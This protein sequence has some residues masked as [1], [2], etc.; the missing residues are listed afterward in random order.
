MNAQKEI[1][2]IRK[3]CEFLENFFYMNAQNKNK[4]NM[5]MRRKK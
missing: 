2:R 4:R 1:E 3:D 5:R